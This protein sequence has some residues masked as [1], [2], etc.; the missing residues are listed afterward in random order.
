MNRR[1][2]VI[3]KDVVAYFEDIKDMIEIADI[4]MT[5]IRRVTE[6]SYDKIKQY[7]NSPEDQFLHEQET[8]IRL[9][10]RLVISRIEAVCF[11]L[12]EL[13]L[14]RYK[15]LKKDPGEEDTAFLTEK[16]KNGGL[17]FMSTGENLKYAFKMFANA[18]NST[19]KL[20]FGPEWEI[21]QRVLN[22]RRGLTHPKNKR[23]LSISPADQND[24]VDTGIWFDK[25]LKELVDSIPRL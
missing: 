23:D 14:I 11:K 1:K 24:A 21:F 9:S 19:Y 10:N 15:M 2:I 22:K 16:R 4:L 20:K 12:K 3:T 7:K 13:T 6:I 25:I 17:K 18:F 8:W 5:D